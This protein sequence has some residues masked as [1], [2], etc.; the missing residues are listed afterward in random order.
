MV[1]DTEGSIEMRCGPAK[2]R[3]KPAVKLYNV[4]NLNGRFNDNFVLQRCLLDQKMRC[5][6]IVSNIP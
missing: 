3:G 5:D 2:H 4:D 1:H 6:Q